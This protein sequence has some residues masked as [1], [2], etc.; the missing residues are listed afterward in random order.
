MDIGGDCKKEK[1]DSFDQWT[2]LKSREVEKLETEVATIGS[3]KGLD[4][5]RDEREEKSGTV[6]TEIEP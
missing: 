4:L 2:F 5:K 6:S 3:Q 1:I